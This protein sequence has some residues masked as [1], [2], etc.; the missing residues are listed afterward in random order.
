[1]PSLRVLLTPP[2]LRLA[3]RISRSH[4]VGI[5][6]HLGTRIADYLPP[7]NVTTPFRGNTEFR[8]VYLTPGNLVDEVQTFSPWIL[9]LSKLITCRGD[10]F[11][12]D[13]LYIDRLLDYEEHRGGLELQSRQF[14]MHL[15]AMR[16]YVFWGC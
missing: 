12:Q 14:T 2:A 3:F 1:M 11:G 16:E 7:C 15:N 9:L 5:D 6:F 10:K 13:L 8:E 4:G